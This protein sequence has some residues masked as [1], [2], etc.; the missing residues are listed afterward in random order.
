MTERAE[1]T[2]NI[3]VAGNLKLRQKLGAV[4]HYG[5]DASFVALAA[6]SKP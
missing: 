6:K 1:R 2:Y 3:A 5:F 4:A